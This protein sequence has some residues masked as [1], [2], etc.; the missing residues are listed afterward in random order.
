[1]ETTE[2]VTFLE[3]YVANF[4]LF[5]NKVFLICLTQNGKK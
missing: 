2:L 5:N 4:F 1:M 3:N